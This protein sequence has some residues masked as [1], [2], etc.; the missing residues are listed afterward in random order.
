[1]QRV[2]HC[3][4]IAWCCMGRFTFNMLHPAWL[5]AQ[6]KNYKVVCSKYET[7]AKFSNLACSI[8]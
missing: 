1:M 3:Q 2:V 8:K 6:L 5:K 4:H 7:V